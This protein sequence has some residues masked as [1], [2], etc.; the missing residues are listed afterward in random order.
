ML[1]L[2]TDVL[3]DFQRNYKPACIWL[4]SLEEIP[5]VPG[6]VVM[7]LIQSAENSKQILAAQKLIA[8]LSIVWPTIGDSQ[9]ALNTFSELHLSHGLGLLDS[10]I[11]TTAIGLSATLV[12]FNL[13]HYRAISDLKTLQPYSK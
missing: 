3:I 1:I 5:S 9:R 7:E 6:F 2:D 11:A 12:T 4:S 13:K 10:L 8:P